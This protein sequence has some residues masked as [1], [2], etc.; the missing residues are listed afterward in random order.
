MGC[1]SGRDAGLHADRRWRGPVPYACCRY[2]AGRCLLFVAQWFAADAA[3]SCFA[4]AAGRVSRCD[5]SR[6]ASRWC[7]CAS[8][9]LP[10]AFWPGWPVSWREAA[11]CAR[12]DRTLGAV[13]GAAWPRFVAC[14][15]W[16][17]ASPP[18]TRRS[19][20]KSRGARR[21]WTEV[22]ILKP[23]LLTNLEGICLVRS[24]AAVRSCR[25]DDRGRS[26]GWNTIQES[27]ASSVLRPSIS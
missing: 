21:S 23:A 10:V 25:L 14:W 1:V 3:A 20:G 15:L 17:L 18:C 12:Q 24:A 22:L 27:S 13:F 19:G 4:R 2:R 8:S 16:W 5:T 9:P 26:N 6:L 7:F 11:G